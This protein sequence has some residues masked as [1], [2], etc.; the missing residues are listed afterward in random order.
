MR[1]G[2]AP[3]GRGRDRRRRR[4]G[5]PRPRADRSGGHRQAG[6]RG[7]RLRTAG[8]GARTGA[9][10]GDN[11][12]AAQA[13]A[14][15]VGITRVLAGVLPENKA[16]EV[17]KLQARGEVVAMVGDSINDA[18]AIAQADLGLAIGTGSDVAIETAAIALVCGDPL[19]AADAI[20][21]AR[22]FTPRG[23]SLA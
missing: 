5:W 2:D 1:R 8:V 19:A 11:Q 4:L 22:R 6:R 10:T 14:A 7:S 9:F 17:A 23:A 20:L 12:A 16:A 18:P 13:V 15:R 21:L 3:G